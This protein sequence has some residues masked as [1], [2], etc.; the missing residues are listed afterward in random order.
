MNLQGIIFDFDGTIADTLPICIMSFQQTFERVMGKQFTT[1]EVYSYF[2]RSEEGII[3]EIAPNHYDECLEA[4]MEI[5]RNNHHLCPNVFDGMID[6]LESISDSGLKMALI[7]GKGPNAIK[8]SLDYLNLN[9]YFEYVEAG[10]AS[11]SIKT[12]CIN[13]IANLWEIDHSTIA[14]VGDQPSDIIDSKK[15][16]AK[17]IAVS[18][19]KTSNHIELQ[20]HNPD[21]LFDNVQRFK[22]WLNTI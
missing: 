8:I 3:K 22:E 2:G 13:K 15:A 5:Y 1:E 10:D 18:W 9:K 7:T 4:Y 21:L 6:I 16:N 11:G 14:Y 20:K 17:A 19:A 12:Q